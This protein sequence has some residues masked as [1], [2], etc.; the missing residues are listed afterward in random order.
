MAGYPDDER[1]RDEV[2][3]D[4]IKRRYDSEL[5][6]INDLDAKG[7]NLIGYVSVIVGL[8]VGVGT[9]Q[10]LGK[11][12]S[13]EYYIPYFLGIF[14]L[15]SSL[16]VALTAVKITSWMT[17]PDVKRLRDEY[18]KSN[19]LYGTVI[20][21]VMGT[22]TDAVVEMEDKSDVKARRINWSWY[23][24]IAGL[25]S[26]VSYVVIFSSTCHITGRIMFQISG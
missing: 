12:S 7:H 19:Y 15:L 3:F 2:V 23:I 5:T 14:L 10:I 8:L 22:M 26:V 17:V 25:V 18:L 11:L 13:P 16:I 6:R 4:L 24:L 20:S 1:S 9:F 21:R